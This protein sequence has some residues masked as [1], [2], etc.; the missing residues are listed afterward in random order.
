MSDGIREVL[1]SVETKL[2]TL[3]DKRDELKRQVELK[4]EEVRL[5]EKVLEDLDNVQAQVDE[6]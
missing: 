2:K 6:N 1:E 4:R 5:L 3:D